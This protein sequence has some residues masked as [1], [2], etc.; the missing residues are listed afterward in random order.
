MNPCTNN[1]CQNGGVCTVTGDDSYSC[2]CADGYYGHSCEKGTDMT[3]L[4]QK[5]F[6]A[7]KD[8]CAY[9]N[10]SFPQWALVNHFHAKMVVHAQWRVLTHSLANALRSLKETPAKNVSKFNQSISYR[11]IIFLWSC[12]LFYTKHNI[13]LLQ[14]CLVH[15][16][17]RQT[18][19]KA[20]AVFFLLS[21]V[22]KLIT[23]V[24]RWLIADCGVHLTKFTKVNGLTAVR[25]K[26][27]K[28]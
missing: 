23:L 24:P 4:F 2:K 25:N 28:F 16:A 20:V 18:M 14:G 22:G 7:V 15:L 19:L 17:R 5:T 11:N 21:M 9:H 1:P 26:N 6:R 13:I 27:H 3:N 10:V 8:K 12:T